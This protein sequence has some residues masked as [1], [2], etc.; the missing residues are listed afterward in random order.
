M[1]A[2]RVALVVF[3]LLFLFLSPDSQTPS[4]SQQRDLGH[5]IFEERQALSL[6][7]TSSYGGLNATSNRWLNITGLRQNDGYAW[8]LL[9]NV[10]ERAREQ[11]QDIHNAFEFTSVFKNASLHL[12]EP[13]NDGDKQN[14]VDKSLSTMK[15]FYDHAPLYSNVTGIV[16]GQWT[17][18]KIGEGFSSPS[19]N[20]SALTPRTGYVSQNY[21]R[22]ITG[23]S[24]DLR[25]HIHEGNGDNF[26]L[27]IEDDGLVRDVKATM[28]IKDESSSGDG[29][30]TSLF[31]VHYPL[32]GGVILTTTSEKYALYY[33]PRWSQISNDSGLR[34]SLLYRISLC[35]SD[36][37]PSPK[38]S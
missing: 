18:S 25:F 8:D 5:S 35:L 32:Q 15:P 26:V 24:G 29:W 17:R 37:F 3:L 12:G 31:G 16:R 11:L 33:A 2:S 14:I 30:E 22:N 4:L 34:V 23:R 1:D 19:L 13:A 9:L 28:T 36:L 6:L 7:N 10:Q 38:G 20:L 27:G 21:N